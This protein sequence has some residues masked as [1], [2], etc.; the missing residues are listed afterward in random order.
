MKT[1]VRFIARYW[2]WFNRML[3]RPFKGARRGYWY[4]LPWNKTGGYPA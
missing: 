1:I 3:Y 4:R 2:P